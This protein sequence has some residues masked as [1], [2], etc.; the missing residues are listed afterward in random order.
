MWCRS[1]SVF[2][3]ANFKETQLKRIRPG[4][5]VTIS[6][7]AYGHRKFAGVVDSISPAA[8]SV[9]TL[10]PPDNATGNFTKI[11]QRL[12]VRDP[13]AEGRRQ[14]EPAARGHVGLRHRRY[15]RGR[16]RCRQRGRP[17]RVADAASEIICGDRATRPITSPS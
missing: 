15:Q 1:T 3:D 11:V 16:R 7:D 13:R 8:G 9:F 12:P 5:P 2:I 6:V 14:A 10:L 17:R 4:Q